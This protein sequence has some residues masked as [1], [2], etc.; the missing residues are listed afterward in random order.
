M[1]QPT[2]VE[3]IFPRNGSIESMKPHPR[4][5]LAKIHMRVADGSGSCQRASSRRLSGAL[6]PPPL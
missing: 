1:D 2:K 5:M 4:L 3:S 6:A